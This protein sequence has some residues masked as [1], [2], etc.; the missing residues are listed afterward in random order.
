M[1]NA[2]NYSD[3]LEYA[4]RRLQE[5]LV[6]LDNGRPIRVSGINSAKGKFVCNYDDLATQLQSTCFIEEL[7]LTPVPLGFFSYTKQASAFCVRKPTRK[8]V[9]GLS[10]CNIHI[11]NTLNY[12]YH[13]SWQFLLQPILNSYPKVE[14][15]I[16]ILKNPG[17]VGTVGFS[18]EFAVGREK[19]NT[20]M[21]IIYRIHKVGAVDNGNLKL[22]E[23]KM[24]LSQ[25]LE[26]C[27]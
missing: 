11:Y 1:Q 3:D 23:D 13:F 20:P 17:H 16:N 12:E 21:H 5:T 7:D 8:P 10:S 15:A 24:F 25:H 14:E 2:I 22:D 18:R 19:P 26:E 6:R 4:R 9:Q 27:V